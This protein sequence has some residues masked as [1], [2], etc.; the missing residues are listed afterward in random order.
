MRRQ[1]DSKVIDRGLEAIRP[2]RDQIVRL[3]PHSKIDQRNFEYADLIK[4]GELGRRV[5]AVVEKDGAPLVYLADVPIQDEEIGRSLARLLG[6]RGETALLVEVHDVEKFGLQGRAWSCALDASAYEWMDFSRPEVARSVLGDLQ[7]GLWSSVGARHQEQRLRDLLVSSVDTV[8]RELSSKTLDKDSRSDVLAL[9]GRALFTRFLIDRGILSVATAPGLK[10]ALSED[11]ALAFSSPRQAAAVCVWLDKTFNGE[12][13][14][15]SA[16][17]GYLNYFEALVDRAPDA[18]APLSWIVGRTDVGGQ[19]PLWDRLNF[20]YI[21]VGTLSEVYENYVR[22]R[23]PIAAKKTSVYFTPRHIARMMVRQALAGVPGKK[24]AHPKVLDPAVGAGVF[25]SLSFRE[26]ARRHAE[27]HG[28]WPSTKALRDILY[29][30]LRGMDINA[31]AL[32]LAALTLYLTAIELDADPLPPEKLRFEARLIGRIL[33]DVSR[34][35]FGSL[36]EKKFPDERCEVVLGNPPWTSIEATDSDEEPAAAQDADRVFSALGEECIREL[37]IERKEPYSHPDKVPDLAFVWNAT[38]WATSGG[39]IAFVVHQRLIIKRSTKW[40]EARRALFSSIQVDG[41]V[42]GSEF[43]NHNKLIWPGVESPFCVLFAR[44]KKPTA[45]HHT[46]LLTLTVEPPLTIRRHVRLDPLASLSVELEEFDELPGGLIPRLKGCELDR[47]LIRRWHNRV[48][49][50]RWKGDVSRPVR[51]LPLT[52]VGQALGEISPHVPARGMKKG[53]KRLSQPEWFEHLPESTPE[54]AAD[55]DQSGEVDASLFDQPFVAREIRS[56]PGRAWFEPPLLLLRQAGGDLKQTRRALLVQPSNGLP[57]IYPFAFVGTPLHNNSAA[58]VAAKF[59]GL[60][61]NSSIFSYYQSLTSTQFGFQIKAFLSEEMLSTPVLRPADAF[62]SG[63]TTPEEVEKL[64]KKLGQDDEK[65]SALIDEWAHRVMG[66]DDRERQLVRD[67]L[68]IAYP[69]GAP[70]QSGYSWIGKQDVG[71]YVAQLAIDLRDLSDDVDFASLRH[72]HTGSAL[73]GWQFVA[74]RHAKK[75]KSGIGNAAG[76]KPMRSLEVSELL[77]VV[78]DC[79]PDGQVW[80]AT[81]QGEFVFGQL[82]LKRLWLP[83]RATLHAPKIAAWVS[84]SS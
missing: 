79:Y 75:S 36:S 38:R 11:G 68:S 15:L 84:A 69:I 67:T 24:V 65:T 14:P 35:P 53:K 66:S 74:W 77:R 23:S 31:D 63:A 9:V 41:I 61:V 8:S 18:L 20:S 52:T 4:G 45:D 10:S 21:P 2:S 80:A 7:E 55:D 3:S 6:N 46:R 27:L 22:S 16:P 64:F 29:G 54:I 28:K 60:W 19:M 57:V 78:R 49:S 13:M 12:F 43:A 51:Q 59:I 83:S 82:A 30:Q 1:A 58:L 33:H 47:M 71:A 26:L 50:S 76:V 37:G 44:N 40:R 5:G 25:L 32:N 39:I 34:H 56:S 17:R 42:D 81:K 62:E 73:S 70:R 72:I 48:S